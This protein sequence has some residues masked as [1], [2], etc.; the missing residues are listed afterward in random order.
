MS[1]IHWIKLKT[2]MFDDEK[3]R[4]IEAMPEADSILIIWVRLL[5][6]AGK[7]NDDGLIYIQRDMPYTDE[8]LAALFNKKINVIRL[9]LNTLSKFQMIGIRENGM[10]QVTN[11]EKHQ[12]VEQMEHV[13]NLTADR[14]RR[15]RDKQKS[16][17]IGNASSNATVTLRNATDSDS[18]SD[19]E[20]NKDNMFPWQSVIDYLNEKTGKRFKHTATN[21][22]VIMARHKEGYT[23][24]DMRKVIDSKTAE[25]LRDVKMNKFLQPSTLFRASKF[26]GYVNNIPAQE[27]S[28]KM[29]L[30]D[31]TGD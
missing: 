25:W 4:L 8:T 24:D 13:R 18:D 30:K 15:Y 17:K 5:V 2:S 16:K 1:D 3:I 26:E 10:L 14:V 23:A 19:T 12:N 28:L 9:A 21:K 31:W 29:D 22:T 27:Q 6:L 7:T 20:V 11:W